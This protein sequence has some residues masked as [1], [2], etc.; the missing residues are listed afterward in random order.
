MHSHQCREPGR[1]PLELIQSVY[2]CIWERICQ[3]ILGHDMASLWLLSPEYIC[4]TLHADPKEP[5]LAATALPPLV[6]DSGSPACSTKNNQRNGSNNSLNQLRSSSLTSYQ[7]SGYG[8]LPHSAR[9]SLQEQVRYE[10]AMIHLRVCACVCACVYACI[11]CVLCVL[12]VCLC[13]Y[14]VLCVFVHVV[15]VWGCVWVWVC[16]MQ[17]NTTCARTVKG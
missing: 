6:S 1:G 12:C 16:V 7:S 9:A 14:C 8:S 17:P 10:W 13:V 4:C 2:Q 5:T 11:Y 3:T 15:C